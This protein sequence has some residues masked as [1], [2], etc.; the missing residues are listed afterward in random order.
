MDRQG[1][2]DSVQKASSIKGR[3]QNQPTKK[4]KKTPNK[5]EANTILG[6]EENFKKIKIDVLNWKKQGNGFSPRALQ[7]EHSPVD[8]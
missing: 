1:A 3:N 7:E 5:K 2:P 8:A 6:I 4:K